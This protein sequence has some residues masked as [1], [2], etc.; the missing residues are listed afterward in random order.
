MYSNISNTAGGNVF[1]NV[2]LF[3]MSPTLSYLVSSLYC[4][5]TMIIVII[6]ANR[7]D[8]E[9]CWK[10]HSWVLVLDRDHPPSIHLIQATLH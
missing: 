4:A 6:P 3:I 10:L 5:V 7:L 2:S 9:L 1:N 8:L